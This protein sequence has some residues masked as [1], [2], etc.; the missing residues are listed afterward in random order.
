[1]EQT[2]AYQSQAATAHTQ[3]ETAEKAGTDT[4]EGFSAKA[5]QLASL[6]ND[7]VDRRP[8][9]LVGAAFCGGF[10]LARILKRLSNG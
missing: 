10:V 2:G 7:K 5:Q 4:A 6:G 1:M 3:G 9:L 8:E